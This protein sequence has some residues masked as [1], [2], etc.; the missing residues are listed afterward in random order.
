MRHSNMLVINQTHLVVTLEEAIGSPKQPRGGDAPTGETREWDSA[1][2]TGFQTRD[3]LRLAVKK[4]GGSSI[5]LRV[6]LHPACQVSD[7]AV[8][9]PLLLRVSWVKNLSVERRVGK[10]PV[11]GTE[12]YGTMDV[13]D[14]QMLDVV[15]FGGL[16]VVL[17]IGIF[18]LFSF[19]KK[20]LLPS[21]EALAKQ[22]QYNKTTQQQKK[23]AK[24]KKKAVGK[25]G[26]GKKTEEKPNG[27]IPEQHQSAPTLSS[28]TIKKPNVL[29][30]HEEQKPNGPVM[31]AAASNKSEPAPADSD[32]PLYLPYKTLV[33]T[34]SST[35]FSEGEAQRLIEI[36]R[37]KAGIVQDTWHTAMQ[38]GGP[39]AVLE[40]QLEEKEKQLATEQE[41]AAAARNKRRELSKELVAEWAKV[42]A[43]EGKLKVQLLACEQELELTQARMQASHQQHVKKTQQLQDKIRTL[44][45]QLENGPNTQLARLQQ[46]NS[47][48]RDALYQTSSWL[49]SK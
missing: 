41:A 46:E 19:M 20:V 49:E 42:T 40:R 33:S 3:G 39:V 12:E 47:M 45:E 29:P 28:V 22:G 16:M 2:E 48:L 11:P 43:L 6:G 27:K 10:D 26:M 36:L 38:K 31:K 8:R 13:Y 4:S 34:V 24:K 9:S 32:G 21:E 1:E 37:E 44:Q 25:K 14:P 18:L 7:Q 15:V 35:A 30:T 5:F 23:E 17:A